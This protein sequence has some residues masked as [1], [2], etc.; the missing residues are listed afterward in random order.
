MLETLDPLALSFAGGLL[1]ASGII[2]LRKRWL[3]RRNGGVGWLIGG[4]LAVF[5]GFVVLGQAWGAELGTTYAL[6][7]LSLAAYALIAATFERRESRRREAREAA[8]D[9]EERPTNW[10]RGVAKA[11]LAI[12]LAGVASIGLDVA[13]AVALPLPPQDRAVLGGL[14]VPI[15]WGGGMAW[16]LSDPRLVRATLILIAVSALGYGIAFLPKGLS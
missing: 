7:G 14:L 9:P 1:L 6:G 8:Y 11:L 4:W 15:L 3:A 12:V 10:P 2:M 13:V 5:V 16:T